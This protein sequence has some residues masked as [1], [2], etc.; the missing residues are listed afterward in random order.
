M[1]TGRAKDIIIRNGE[2][3]SPKEIEDILIGHPGVAEIAI[4]GLPDART[5][6]RACAVIVPT[7]DSAPDV[8]E[9]ARFPAGPGC[10]QVQSARAGGDL[11]GAAEERCRQGAQAPDSSGADGRRMDDMQVAIVTGATGGIGFGCA[12]KLAESGMAVLGHRAQ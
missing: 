9:S 5:G 3:I 4:V 11:G 7:D 1:V 12:T 6:E 10:R 8:G 2:N